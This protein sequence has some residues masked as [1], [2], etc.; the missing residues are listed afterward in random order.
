[1]RPLARAV[2]SSATGLVRTATLAQSRLVTSDEAGYWAYATA[3]GAVVR[4]R[5]ADPSTGYVYLADNDGRLADP[6]WLVT[7]AFGGG[8]Q[9]YWVD[10]S[11]RACVPGYSEAGWAH[12]TL[13]SGRVLR[14]A[15]SSG[16]S[17]RYADND[18]RLASGWLVTA[19]LG[20]GLQRY[21]VGAGGVVAT[22]RLVDP[23]SD[24]SGWWAYATPSGAVVRGRWADPSTGLVYLA[25]NDGRLAGPGWAVRDCG[26]GLQRY[27]VDAS[28]RACVPGV[29]DGRL[30][31]LHARLRVRGARQ[32]GRPL[33]GPRLP[34]RQR[35][36][37]RRPRL[38]RGKLRRRPP[39]LL[40]GRLRARLRA[41]PLD[42]RLGA[43]HARLRVRAARGH[44]VR[45]RRGSFSPTTTAGS[46]SATPRAAGS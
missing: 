12:Y 4:G 21:W 8:L 29:L 46:P 11:A 41:G 3:S 38:G 10:A 33:H 26:D 1:M 27:W 43:L 44:A 17:T 6:G 24:G 14:G 36:A 35:R 23:A 7:A 22:S 25:D 28:A 16:G 5:W 13:A 34:R 30:G 20:G 40:G 32:V 42:G 37:A 9:R 19:A 45:P 39:A 18:G 15:D 2:V 31:A